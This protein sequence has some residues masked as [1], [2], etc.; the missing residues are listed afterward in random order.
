MSMYKTKL[1]LPIRTAHNINLPVLLYNYTLF[2]A[3]LTSG[4]AYMFAKSTTYNEDWT[5][6]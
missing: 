6:C 2:V 1:V 4:E 5:V 3:C